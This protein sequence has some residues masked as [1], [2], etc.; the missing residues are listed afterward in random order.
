MIKVGEF[1]ELEILRIVEQGAY[2]EDG[3]RGL[4]LPNRFLHENA[5]VG[6][7]VKVFIYHDN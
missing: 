4:L 7:L 1:Q 3:D 6:E 5:Q 2:L